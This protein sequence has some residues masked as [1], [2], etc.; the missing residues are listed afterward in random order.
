[1]IQLGTKSWENSGEEQINSLGYQLNEEEKL[2][3]RKVYLHRERT[4]YYR[5]TVNYKWL[6]VARSHLC[7]SFLVVALV[8]D[9][10]GN[11]SRRCDQTNPKRSACEEFY[12]QD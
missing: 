2:D 10:E 4:K 8:G 11:L 6:G 9:G 7:A 1:M 3:E 5:G 12:V